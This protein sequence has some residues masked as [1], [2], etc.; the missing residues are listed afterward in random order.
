MTLPVV[1][2]DQHFWGFMQITP[3]QQKSKYT[4]GF[5]NADEVVF[6]LLTQF[7]RLKIQNLSAVKKTQDT[8]LQVTQT[9]KVSSQ[10]ST[11]RSLA[12]FML[13]CDEYLSEYLQFEG[14]GILFKDTKRSGMFSL[15]QNYNDEQQRQLDELRMKKARGIELSVEER[16]ADIER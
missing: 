6:K 5:T 3:I 14:V 15:Q 8:Q 16:I 13:A 9:L 7:L 12:D 10:I 11:Q 1:L 2:S 4:K